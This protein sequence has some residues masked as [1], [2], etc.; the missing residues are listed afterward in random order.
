MIFF[1]GY[2]NHSYWLPNPFWLPQSGQV[3]VIALQDIPHMFSCIHAWQILK[4]HRH[5]QQNVNVIRQQTQS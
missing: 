5:V 1:S 2:K 4:P 3:Q